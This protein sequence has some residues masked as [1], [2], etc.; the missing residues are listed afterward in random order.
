MFRKLLLILAAIGV[1]AAW[2]YEVPNVSAPTTVQVQ[3][4][5]VAGETEAP[6]TTDAPEFAS[7]YDGHAWYLTER[8]GNRSLE[9]ID[10]NGAK[11]GFYQ[12]ESG[13]SY[14]GLV[15]NETT[16]KQVEAIGF[17]AVRSYNKGLNRYLIPDDPAFD[18]Y[19][20]DGSYVTFFFDQHD[21]NR[22][23]GIL[24]V[25]TRVEEASDGYYG[26]IS[27]A[28]T[29]AN[30]QLMRI[31]MNWDREKY[32]LSALAD[33][34]PLV[35]VVRAYSQNMAANNFFS[36]TDPSGKDPFD[37]MDDAGLRYQMAGENLAMGQMSVF[38][39]HWG[40]M[41]SLGH[42]ENILQADYT[43][44]AVGLAHGKENSPYY[45]INFITPR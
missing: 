6:S 20:I 43:H 40:L 35:P 45:T 4:T 22:L 44:A 28:N 27:E 38:H 18:V 34:E 21:D 29:V 23:K 9:L 15:L 17:D 25:E 11:K 5:E 8:S 19:E 26:D 7:Q 2:K 12:F 39:A 3:S 33:Y 14:E 16:R 32:G 30:E 24:S 10:A 36:H 37:R 13:T 31:L 41:N 42:R 1:Y